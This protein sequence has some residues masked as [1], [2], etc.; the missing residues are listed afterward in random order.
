MSE[1]VAEGGQAAVYAQARR[2]RGR[3]ECGGDGFVVEVCADAQADRLALAF[4]QV[5]ES[6]LEPVE[7]GLVRFYDGG[8]GVEPL[9]DPKPL[10][11]AAFEAPAAHGH[12]QDVACD[13][14]QPRHRGAGRAVAEPSAREPRL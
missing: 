6:L 9:E 3:A 5:G 7:P 8:L 14:E 11:R 13:S 2:R 1:S 10:A 4:R 12:K